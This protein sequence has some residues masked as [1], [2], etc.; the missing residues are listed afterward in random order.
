VP[1]LMEIC[2]ESVA[3]GTI[4]LMQISHK[5]LAKRLLAFRTLTTN[6]TAIDNH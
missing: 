2:E 5:L 6:P 4:F 3:F 1:K